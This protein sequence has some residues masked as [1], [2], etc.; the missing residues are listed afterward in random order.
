MINDIQH[1]QPGWNVYG[2][3]EEKIG[4]VSEIGANYLL[5]QKGWLFTT[6]TYV[7]FSAIASV[8]E[9][10]VVLN[11][12]KDQ[13]DQF[14]WSSPPSQE[15]DTTYVATSATIDTQPRAAV[16]PA[17]TS[18][19]AAGEEISVPV[20][21]EE[22][23]IGTREVERGGVRVTT[24]VEERPV[25]EQVTLRD[26]EVTVERRP[27]DRAITDADVTDFQEGVFEVRERDEEAIVNK[28]AQVVEEVVISKDVE[29]RTETV[30]DTLRRTD[31]NIEELPG[32][33]RAIGG[34]LDRTDDIGRRNSRENF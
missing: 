14:D 20:T 28:R 9:D 19:V 29:E 24:R 25:Q 16:A 33:Q 1:I 12:S 4:D 7:P 32:Q 3:D 21:E 2:R 34:D 13:L 23:R 10:H 6:D 15:V 18:D 30:Q 31:V 5:V 22:L 8:G 26:E 17:S 27:V 11:V